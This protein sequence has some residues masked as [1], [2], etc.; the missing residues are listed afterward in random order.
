MIHCIPMIEPKDNSTL[1]E[2]IALI[3]PPSTPVSA[4][5]VYP[6]EVMPVQAYPKSVSTLRRSTRIS[7]RS[8]QV[9]GEQNNIEQPQLRRSRRISQPLADIF[10][11]NVQSKKPQ[12]RQS[13]FLEHFEKMT[14]GSNKNAKKSHIEFVLNILNEGTLKDLQMLPMIGIKTAY[15]IYTYRLTNG[16]FETIESLKD[17]PFWSEKTYQRFVKQNNL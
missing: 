14:I 12:L 16:T 1:N 11:P 9:S 13:T 7:M 2:S 15:Q 17:M 6:S 4:K 8:M 3:A 5:N 10:V